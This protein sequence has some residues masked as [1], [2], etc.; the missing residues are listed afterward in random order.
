MK[1]I[2]QFFHLRLGHESRSCFKQKV[3]PY[4]DEFH[5]ILSSLTLSPSNKIYEKVL[6]LAYLCKYLSVK[7]VSYKVYSLQIQ[8]RP[9]TH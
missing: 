7:Y 3:V 6:M 4:F 1:K 5:A 8:Y 9:C 2:C